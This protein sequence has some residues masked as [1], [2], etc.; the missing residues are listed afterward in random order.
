M[1]SLGI[2]YDLHCPADPREQAP[3]RLE[4]RVTPMD[5]Q[6]WVGREER[7]QDRLTP[8][9]LARLYATLD[10]DPASTTAAPPTRDTSRSAD[11]PPR[12]TAIFFG[13]VVML[14]FFST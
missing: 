11:Q 8:A 13:P 10:R 3:E 1:S 12:S 9:M 5:W 14:S 4:Q 2:P 6:D 7:A